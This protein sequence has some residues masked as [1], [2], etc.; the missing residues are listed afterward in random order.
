M[1]ATSASVRWPTTSRPRRTHDRRASSSRMPVDSSTAVARPPDLPPAP[2]ASRISSRVSARR[3]SAASRWSRSAIRPGLSV[4]ARRPPGRSRTSRSTER[5]ASSEPAM[6]RPSSRVAG[7]MTTSHSSRTPRATASTGSKLRD[8]SSQA[9]TEPSAWASAAT[10]R[11][12][13]VR[14]LE[15]SPRIATLAEVG[16]PPGPRIASSAAKPVWMT[17]WPGSG[18]IPAAA[19]LGVGLRRIGRQG[20]GPDDPR[21]CRTPASLEARERG[22]HIS[23]GGRHRTAILEHLFYSINPRSTPGYARSAAGNDLRSRMHLGCISGQRPGRT[24][25]TSRCARSTIRAICIRHAYGIAATFSGRGSCILARTGRR[26]TTRRP[27]TPATRGRDPVTARSREG[28]SLSALPCCRCPPRPPSRV[29]SD[30]SSSSTTTP[31]SSGSCA[32]TSS[33]RA[34][35]S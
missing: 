35:R 26:R 25:G 31:R 18:A 6:P 14:P 12:S 32:P 33:A 15:P 30:R 2:G 5:P 24:R 27:A 23:T 34:T 9:T 19:G 11:A 3:A 4:L 16:R 13:V 20:E 1:W 17:R 8:R 28:P 10:R 21:S 7:V 29:P 22:V